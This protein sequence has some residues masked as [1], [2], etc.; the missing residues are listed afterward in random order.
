MQKDQ[1]RREAL[2]VH[3]STLQ[4]M[5]VADVVVLT[6]S[7]GDVLEIR[8]RHNSENSVCRLHQGW[9]ETLLERAAFLAHIA[10][11]LMVFVEFRVSF[12]FL[13]CRSLSGLPIVWE[14][15]DAFHEYL[16]VNEDSTA[17]I[18]ADVVLVVC[19]IV[20]IN[21]VYIAFLLL[22]DGCPTGERG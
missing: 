13:D 9:V 16:V 5:A 18:F 1:V 2:L 6:L 19:A 11:V 4:V 15:Q 17:K 3:H 14:V 20:L 7:R 12:D 8:P 10:V 21:S 22:A